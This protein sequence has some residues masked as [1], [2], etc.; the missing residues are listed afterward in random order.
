M[1]GPFRRIHW[2]L[3]MQNAVESDAVPSAAPEQKSNAGPLRNPKHERFARA[4]ALLVSV[5]EA[6]REAGYEKMTPGNAMKLDRRKDI[7]GRI[8]ALSAIDEEMLRMRRERVEARLNLA[9]YGNILKFATID[10]ET[11]KLIA[12]DWRR[13]AESELAVTISEFSFDGKTGD[14]TKFGRDNAL[15]AISQIRDMF[16]MKAP[17]KVAPTNPDG[18]GPAKIELCW[19]DPVDPEPEAND[20]K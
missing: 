12:I 7:R 3:T 19:L 1:A 13:L 9:A 14:L 4:R 2:H 10:Q 15:N 20:G 16:G 5:L 18:D 17:T 8:A 11:G 6:A